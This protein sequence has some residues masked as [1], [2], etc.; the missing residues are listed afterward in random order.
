[1]YSESVIDLFDLL[2]KPQPQISLLS[3]EFLQTVKN[4]PTKNL[5]VTEM[6]RYLA[7]EIKVKSGTNLTLQKDF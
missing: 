2:E 3:E 1:M 5:W 4:S 7:S 6:E